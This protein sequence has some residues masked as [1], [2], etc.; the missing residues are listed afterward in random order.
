[1]HSN[2]MKTKQDTQHCKAD[3]GIIKAVK[4]IS[5]FIKL[6]NSINYCCYIKNLLLSYLRKSS[7]FEHNLY[8]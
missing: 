3:Y 7:Q 4:A 1:M 2:T 6:T 8:V 5:N